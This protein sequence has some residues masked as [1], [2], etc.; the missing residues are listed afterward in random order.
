MSDAQQRFH[1]KLKLMKAKRLNTTRGIENVLQTKDNQQHELLQ[2]LMGARGMREKKQI[3]KDIFENKELMEAFA[4]HAPQ[5]MDSIPQQKIKRKK[6]KKNKKDKK[7]KK[8]EENKENK[9]KETPCELDRPPFECSETQMKEFGTLL[10]DL[11]AAQT[12][13]AQTSAAQTSD[14]QTSAVQTTHHPADPLDWGDLLE[15]LD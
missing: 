8:D 13:D 9:A 7:D 10:D 11:D 5:M 3:L 6:H 14:A 12:S 1:Q 2:E 15:D 4:K